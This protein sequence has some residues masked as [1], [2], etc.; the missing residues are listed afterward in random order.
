[1]LLYE[2]LSLPPPRPRPPQGPWELGSL[3]LPILQMR[4]HRLREAG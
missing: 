2:V 1:M 4:K 3:I